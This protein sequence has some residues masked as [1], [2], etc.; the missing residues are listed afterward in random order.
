MGMLLRLTRAPCDLHAH[1]QNGPELEHARSV[2]KRCGLGSQL[3]SGAAIFVL[4]AEEHEAAQR[5][6]SEQHLRLHH[7]VVQQSLLPLVR[8]A[9]QALRSRLN[10]R[11][12]S[13]EAIAYVSGSQAV[14]TERTFLTDNLRCLR[15]PGSV[16]QSTT[17][18]NGGV[19]PRRW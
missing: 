18:A 4:D 17:E 5:V 19:N 13:Q 15:N 6:V 11:V 1:L 12:R 8:E 3:P 7:V 16:A 10:V 14:V 9:V 2:M